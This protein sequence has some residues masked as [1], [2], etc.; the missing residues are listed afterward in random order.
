M[1][2]RCS[3]ANPTQIWLAQ[4]YSTWGDR[5]G[6]CGK[7]TPAFLTMSPGW[8]AEIWQNNVV[9]KTT[10]KY[11]LYRKVWVISLYPTTYVHSFLFYPG[12]LS[13]YC[14]VILHSYTPTCIQSNIYVS[15]THVSRWNI[16]GCV[17][18]AYIYG[19]ALLRIKWIKECKFDIIVHENVK[20]F[21]HEKMLAFLGT[22]HMFLFVCLFLCLQSTQF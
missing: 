7:T 11:E 22:S 12:V 19:V 5:L 17:W 9:R 8:I 1:G 3:Q 14:H 13:R 21:P 18:C 15:W 16:W 10:G 2:I 6:E 20:D 4:D